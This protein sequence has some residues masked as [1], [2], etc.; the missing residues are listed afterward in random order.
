MENY[1]DLDYSFDDEKA[2]EDEEDFDVCEE[3]HHQNNF[4]HEIDSMIKD[5]NEVKSYR[6]CRRNQH[7]IPKTKNS[8]I[9]QNIDSKVN[10][11]FLSTSIL[12]DDD[13][14][15][16]R[17]IKDTNMHFI[18]TSVANTGKVLKNNWKK[19]KKEFSAKLI[20]I[21][22]E[23]I[24]ES[25]RSDGQDVKHN[26]VSDYKTFPNRLNENNCGCNSENNGSNNYCNN[27]QCLLRY[28]D[29]PTKF[30]N[31]PLNESHKTMYYNE[32][33]LEPIRS[34]AFSHIDE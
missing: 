7:V 14:E 16:K 9:D 28:H 6:G 5:P 20:D 2:L 27:H 15:S 23:N 29:M 19:I 18:R 12:Q 34:I 25:P 31:V 13:D 30:S 10:K 11:K 33:I 24:K 3:C 8:P 4:L 21:P 22:D 26:K 17:K 1:D 32:P